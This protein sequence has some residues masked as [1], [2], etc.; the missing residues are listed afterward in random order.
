[1]TQTPPTRRALGRGLAALIP[2]AA[3]ATTTE[4][5]V[6]ESNVSRETGL[7]VKIINDRIEEAS[8][9]MCVPDIITAR[10][11]A[12][13]DRLIDCVKPWV[14]GDEPVSLILL[15]GEHFQKEIDAAKQSYSFDCVVHNSAID[16]RGAVLNINNIKTL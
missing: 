15:K 4:E 12:P 1:M 9:Y 11:F 10:A 7:G 5:E 8:S 3:G 14:L 13:L 16:E 6:T 2:G